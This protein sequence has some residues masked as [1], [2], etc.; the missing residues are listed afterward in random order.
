M[1]GNANSGNPNP[2]PDTRFGGDRANPNFRNVLGNHP[3]SVRKS[4]QHL[5]RQPATKNPDGKFE[6]EL[7][8][9]ATFAQAIAA[10]RIEAALNVDDPGTQLRCADY[11]TEQ[12]DG[13]LAQINLNQEFQQLGNMTVE[14]LREHRKQLAARREQLER[15]TAGED[16]GGDRPGG[17]S[18]AGSETPA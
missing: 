10:Q 1:V 11:I 8:D 12:A 15:L 14:E 16:D 17:D 9:G 13:K 6:I 7:P 4:I 2:S 5:A 3:E 18:P